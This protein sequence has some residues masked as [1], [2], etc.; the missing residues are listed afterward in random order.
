[1]P[2]EPELSVERLLEAASAA[3]ASL[4]KWPRRLGWR[5]HGLQGCN[6][7]FEDL[8]VR[9]RGLNNDPVG[10]TTSRRTR[11]RRRLFDR[12]VGAERYLGSRATR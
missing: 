7:S 2:L 6:L 10:F 3:E 1:L 5:G 11:C 9:R 8:G 4:P 12:D